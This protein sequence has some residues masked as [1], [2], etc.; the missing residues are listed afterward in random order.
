MGNYS[1]VNEFF[2]VGLSEYPELQ[3][4]LF[5]LCLIMYVI[6][7]LGNSLLILISILDSR[8]HTPM[9]FFLRN[10]SFLD[11]CYTSSSIPPMLVV[12]LSERKTISFFGCA[13]QMVVSL[14]LGS[15]E[16]VLL[17]V[18]AYDRY[19]AIC[20][21]LKYPII[22]NKALYVH[23]AAWSWILGCLNS[24][25][26]TV[27][28]MVL[29]FCGNNVIDHLTCEILALLKL[30]CSDISMNMLIMTVASIVLLIIPLLLIFISYIFILSSILR[31]KST[32]GRK[33]AFSTCSAHLTVVILFYGSALFMYMKPKSKYTKASDEIIS[34]S[35]GVVTPMLNPI[36]YSLR[37]KEVKEA[38]NKA[39]HRYL[40]IWKK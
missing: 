22:M 32:E 20:N 7:I 17:A 14:G 19:V 34:L 15:T 3:L 2:L 40:L 36:I 30:I 16:C 10:L 9:Y 8:L 27:L 11:I 18:M 5:M 24:L 39:L 1:A 13:L 38:V 25:M 37:N 35:Y 33:K 21:P 12:F 26:Q 4:F 29:P 6:I 23:M 28:T 31:I